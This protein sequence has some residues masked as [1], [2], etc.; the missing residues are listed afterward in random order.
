M[1]AK[2]FILGALALTFVACEKDFF[3]T[4]SPSAMN[5]SVFLSPSSTEQ[6]IGGIYNIFGEDKSFRNRLCGGYVALNTD[7][8]YSTRVAAR[9]VKHPFTL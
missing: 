7:I 8:E 1:K 2:Y 9:H 6:A 4:D 5:T 3:T